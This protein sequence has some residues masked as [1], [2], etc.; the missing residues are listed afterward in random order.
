MQGS[1]SQAGLL[2]LASID[3]RLTGKTSLLP[4]MLALH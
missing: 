1:D 3:K 4:D 2:T